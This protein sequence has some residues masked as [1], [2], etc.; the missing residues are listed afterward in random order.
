MFFPTSCKKRKRRIEQT[1]ALY[2]MDTF[3]CDFGS[4]EES[5]KN[6]YFVN[7]ETCLYIKHP[8]GN[9]GGMISRTDFAMPN[10]ITE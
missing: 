10:K 3:R 2:T 6:C 1:T 9:L 4:V 5:L 7:E 8:I